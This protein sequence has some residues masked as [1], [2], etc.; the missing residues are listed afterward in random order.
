MKN[1][2]LIV[3]FVGI[4]TS[5]Q[6]QS[7]P[8]HKQAIIQSV[9]AHQA[10]LIRMSDSIWTWAEIAFEEH[11]SSAL[12]AD[13]A[14]KQGFRVTRELAEMPTAFIAEYGAGKPILGILGEFDALPNI[15]QKAVPHKDPLQTG[16]GG[17]ACGHNLFGVGSM[18]A[19]L[20][21]KELME[22][23]KINGTLRFYGTPAEEKFFGKLYFARA[24]LFD[25][26]DVCLDW[27]PSAT[28]HT[29]MQSTQ[30]LI[31]FEVEFHGLSAHA[32]MDPW[33]GRSALDGL[34]FY[35]NG[36]NYLREHIRPSA[37]IHYQILHGGDVANV[38]PDYA[39]LWTRLR[40]SD[41]DYLDKVYARA[42]EI[43]EGASMMAGVTHKITLI[44]GLHEVLVNRRGGEILQ[45]NLEL[46]GPITYTE[47]EIAFAKSIQ[48]SL[49]Y[50]QSGM[51]GS[52]QPLAP[53]LKDPLGYSS[54]VGDVSWL[55]P[56]IRLGVTTA[57]IGTP[58]H[59]WPVVACGG[60]S[61]GHKGM[62]FAA[63]ALG[64]TLVD[65]F[66]DPTLVAEIR[67]EFE[68][69]RGDFSYEAIVPEGPPPIE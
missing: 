50:T 64:I 5:L 47:E 2:L 40:E 41:R 7:L 37:R 60:M 53:T 49:N 54:D 61:I 20:A 25:D 22:K 58:W 18:G 3:C 57:P 19:A 34:E 26:L 15:S 39:K 21:I 33:N 29:D 17:H 65:L 31:D 69:K 38:V 51:D 36:L 1:H 68:E 24:G 66:Q 12:L 6:S 30:A 45:K 14:E 4:C 44:A 8:K 55:V 32:G 59:S 28:T 42:K 46:L 23:G 27:H 9:E 11:K 16:A 35:T 67:K 63:K 52:I 62:L 56:E 13:F 43:A 48:A 10:S